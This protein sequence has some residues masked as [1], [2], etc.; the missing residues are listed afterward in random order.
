MPIYD[1]YSRRKR[2][3]EQAEPD[4][5]QYEFI[6]DT[7]RTQIRYIWDGAIG[8]YYERSRDPFYFNNRTP[9]NNNEG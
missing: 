2:R 4:V 1:I 3:A 8:P 9:D 5:Y 6:P 7:V